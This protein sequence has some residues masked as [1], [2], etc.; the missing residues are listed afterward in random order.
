MKILIVSTSSGSRGGGELSLLYLARALAE[1]GHEVLLWCSRHSRMDELAAAFAPIGKVHRSAYTNTY[2]RRGR[3]LASW[4][5][6]TTATRVAVEWRA[7]APDVI[8]L[9]KQNLEDGL[10]LVAA[11]SQSGL[12][13]LCMIHITQSARY[14]K[15]ALAGP[16][17]FVSRRVLR[18]FPGLLVTTPES[19]VRD[20]QEFLGAGP[21]VRTVPNGVPIPD[22]AKSAAA[23][24]PKRHELGIAED[25][26]LGIAVGRMVPQK[27]PLLFL[28]TAERLHR[29]LPQA[30]FLWVGDGELSKEWD[31][32]V[33]ARKLDHVIRRLPW[34]QDA[35]ALLA[36][37]DVFLHVAE[38][39]GLAF[40]ILEALAAGLPCAIT[41]NLLAEMSFLDATN[42]LAMDAADAWF[43]AVR[44]PASL[45]AIGAAARRLAEEKFSFA[46]MARD[47]EVLYRQSL[48]GTP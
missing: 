17:D 23:R 45:R 10:D 9:N 8:H 30:R 2:D 20:L 16:R 3:S 19:R 4:L 22:A 27:R 5:D 48:S 43:S 15:A 40:A 6:G 31:A 41:P 18:S 34:Q 12:P 14:L 7:L 29:T 32:W 42:S 11:A 46:R 39:E 36:A 37:A 25:E 24:A 33:T 35:P 28:D 13:A 44:N 26:L 47:Y 21:R 38:F 1:L